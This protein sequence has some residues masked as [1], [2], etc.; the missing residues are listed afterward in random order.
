M[1]STVLLV[2]ALSAALGVRSPA[3]CPPKSPAPLIGAA[4]PFEDEIAAFEAA[5]R[6]NPPPRGS[7]LFVGSSS[8][9]VWPNLKAD[10]PNSEVLQRGFGGSTLDQVDHYAPRIVLRYCPRLIVLYAGDNDLAEGRTPEQIIADF[11]TFVS[12]VRPSMPK[13]RIVFVAIKPSTARVTLLEAMRATNTLV[14]K[15]I[16]T[17]PSL[18]YVDVFTPMLGPTGLPRGELFQPDGLHMN[19]QGYAIWRGLLQPMVSATAR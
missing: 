13:T 9:R 11:K 15:Y 19:A 6:I 7:V 4:Q 12:L 17:D 5:D 16:A 3:Q 2:A 10:F 18:T 8:I 1:R 14:R